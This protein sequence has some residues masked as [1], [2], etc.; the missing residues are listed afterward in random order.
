MCLEA[1]RRGV[2]VIVVDPRRSTTVTQLATTWLPVW[3]GTDGAL[4]L[5]V[6]YVL[7]TQDLADRTYLK[8]C[9]LGAAELESYVLGL[10][11]GIPKTPAW[12]S[13]QC[14]TPAA[15]I[16]A[17]A[18]LYGRTKPAALLPG[19]SIQRTLG[20]EDASRLAIALQTV[21]G[22]LGVRGGSA[23]ANGLGSLP[24]PKMGSMPVPARHRPPAVPV[25]RW[26]D[27]ILEGTRGGYDRDIRAIY[28]VGGNFLV[29]GSDVRKN[30]RAFEAVDFAVTHDLFLTPTARY[31]DVVL[32]TTTF[33]E[34][35]DIVFAAGNYVL[36]SNQASPA[37]GG[38]R[39]DYDIFCGL[40][41]RLGFGK[42]YSEGKD[43]EAWLRSFVA[44]SEVPD[45]E[46]FR[47]TG[48]YFG[49]DQQR[50][51]FSD[52]VADPAAHPLHTPSGRIE[53]LSASY[54]AG[55]G[56]PALPEWHVLPITGG[57]PL[58]LVT[59]KSKF[60]V[61]SQNANLAWF[62]QH[63]AA[64]L[65]IHPQDAAARRICAGDPVLVTSPQ[66]AV[67]VPARV[68]DDITLGVVC[69]LEG[70]WPNFATDGVDEAGSPNVLTSTEPTLPSQGS[71]THSVFVQVALA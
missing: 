37:L 57:T 30:I 66:G 19:L 1:K 3:P 23:G 48:I 61:H 65:W 34:R 31:C 60:R 36:F 59:P 22:N 9:A 15:Q 43:E 33:L 51:A 47:R 40:A 39:N 29:Q 44:G 70:V 53:L 6:L 35:Q 21:T 42:R 13:P 28:N 54:A 63:E 5:S 4:M 24:G 38:A 25:Y 32:P 8:R 12:A 69:L 71:R 27:A 56:C 64:A 67:R 11:D 26:P 68:T 18:L 52:F 16:E 45:Y 62:N 20:G 58:R 7:F 17:F 14:G 2:P 49:A 41:E 50:I 10:A 55:S 46:E